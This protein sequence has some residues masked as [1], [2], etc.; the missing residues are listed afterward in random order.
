LFAPWWS[1]KRFNAAFNES[2][3]PQLRADVKE[4]HSLNPL[5]LDPL[6]TL[7]EVDNN[8]RWI[9]DAVKLEPLNPDTWYTLA[10]FELRNGNAR[11]AYAAAAKSYHLDPYG[12]AGQPGNIG[13]QAACRLHIRT[14]G[15]P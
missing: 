2:T 12:P 11:A 9:N 1:N 7:A 15:C 10:A 6:Y 13:I 4:A 3:L 14:T 8:V 5:A